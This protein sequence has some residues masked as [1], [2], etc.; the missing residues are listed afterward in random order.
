MKDWHIDQM[1]VCISTPT[2]RVFHEDILPIIG[3]VYS[4]RDIEAR[5]TVVAFHLHEIVNKP[6]G[7]ADGYGEI[8]FL[9][10]RF[11][12]TKQ[13]SIEVFQSLLSPTP[14]RVKE[15]IEG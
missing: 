11:R 3:C 12:P 8:Y 7:N 10:E 9:S 4:I 2:S 1:V 15:T 5:G 14:T 13:T 6:H